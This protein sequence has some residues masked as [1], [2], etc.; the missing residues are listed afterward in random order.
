[1]YHHREYTVCQ[2]NYQRLEGGL[3]RL[4]PKITLALKSDCPLTWEQ[5]CGCRWKQEWPQKTYVVKCSVSVLSKCYDNFLNMS[6]SVWSCLTISS[7][8]VRS[9]KR[10]DQVA[11]LCCFWLRR[12]RYH[13]WISFMSCMFKPSWGSGQKLFC[14]NS[15]HFQRST[16]ACIL[17]RTYGHMFEAD[18]IV[19]N[20][21]ATDGK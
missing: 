14:S 13:L 8:G 16:V 15:L 7:A 19:K 20:S 3:I 9:R 4:F 6:N 12:E 5:C 11:H 21:Q 10:Q 17:F 2:H 18:N 1:M